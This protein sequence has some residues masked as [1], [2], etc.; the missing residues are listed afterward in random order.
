VWRPSDLRIVARILP[1]WQ[2]APYQQSVRAPTT[3]MG[4][5]DVKGEEGEERVSEVRGRGGEGE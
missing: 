1:D 2:I 4:G 5:G 3:P